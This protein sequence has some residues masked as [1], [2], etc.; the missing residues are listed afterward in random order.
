MEIFQTKQI[1]IVLNGERRQIPADLTLDRLLVWLEMDPARVA[2]EF[3]GAIVRKPAWAVS[4]VAAGSQIEVVWFVGGGSSP[5]MEG[6]IKST[7]AGHSGNT[8]VGFRPPPKIRPSNP[9]DTPLK[10]STIEKSPYGTSAEKSEESSGCRER[11]AN[12]F[13]ERRF[14]HCQRQLAPA[15]MVG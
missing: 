6:R 9:V 7:N 11:G 1:E 15:S 3:N 2:V 4:E 13:F 14:G 5:A 10:S 12:V 8:Q